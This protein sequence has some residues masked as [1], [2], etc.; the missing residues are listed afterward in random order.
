MIVDVQNHIFP[1]EMLGSAMISGIV[2]NSGKVAEFRYRGISWASASD[3]VDV[4][5]QY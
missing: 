1:G 2:N 4:E 5:R 3:F